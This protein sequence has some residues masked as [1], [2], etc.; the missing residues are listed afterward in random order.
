MTIETHLTPSEAISD[1]ET[2]ASVEKKLRAVRFIKNSII[3][4]NAKKLLYR[5]LGAISKLMKLIVECDDEE[6]LLQAIASIGSFAYDGV[7]NFMIYRAMFCS[8]V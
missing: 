6:I 2:N 7:V 5:K 4:S 8:M 3:G 1:L